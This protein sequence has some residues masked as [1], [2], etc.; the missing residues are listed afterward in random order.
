MNTLRVELQRLPERDRPVTPG[1]QLTFPSIQDG[2]GFRV[3]QGTTQT[4]WQVADSLRG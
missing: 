4:R 3:P 2:A 1:R